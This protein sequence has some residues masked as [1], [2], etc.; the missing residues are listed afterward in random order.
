[1][2]KQQPAA[3]SAALAPLLPPERLLSDPQACA[4]YAVQG[5]TP[6]C[7]AAPQSLEELA[8]LMR[9]ASELGAA[10]APWGGG[11]QQQIGAPPARL[12]L[13]VRTE[14]LSRVLLHEP[15][16]LTISVEAG[17]TL[18]ALQQHLAQHGQMLPLDPPL[19]EQATVGGLLVT[20]ADGPRR[21]AYGTLRDL[22]I[23]VTVVEVSGRVSRGGGM[24]VKNVSGFDMMKLYLGS[25][26]TLAL[27]AVANF[28]LLPAPRSSATL[29]LSFARPQ[30]A[31]SYVDALLETQLTPTALEYLNPTAA[32]LLGL[33]PGCALLLRAEGAAP[34]VER[35]LRDG[36]RLGQRCGAVQQQCVQGE[37]EQALWAA[38]ADLPQC[39]ALAQDEAV[40]K[41]ALLPSELPGAIE[42]LEALA[43]ACGAR[44]AV[45]ARAA[46][47]V[48][49]ARLRPLDP[50]RLRSLAEGLG[51]LQ[52]V[53]TP[54]PGTPRWGRTPPGVETMRRIKAEFDPRDILNP[55]RFVV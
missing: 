31:F 14:L 10:V 1:M 53:A 36:D 43:A 34:A 13:V 44:A 12:D 17:I 55:G 8:A 46:S 9:A 19:P 3:L 5:L 16:D 48:C 41:L 32:A 52:W 49:Y 22:L 11:T 38:V 40:L 21:L 28:K 30:A 23:G 26:G 20:G 45:S 15:D 25:F 6:A 42:R 27:I 18:G 51:G 33:E 2:I 4:A 7:V 54:L 50:A 39:A 29:L 37:Q 24:V 35:H 47:G